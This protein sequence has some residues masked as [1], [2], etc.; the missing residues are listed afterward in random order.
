MSDRRAP[1]VSFYDKT[2][3]FALHLPHALSQPARSTAIILFLHAHDDGTS[4]YL[5][6]DTLMEMT[7][8]TRSAQFRALKELIKAGYLLDDGWQ[9]YANGAKTRRRRLDLGAM[10]TAR[11]AEKPENHSATDGTETSAHS[12]TGG[13]STVPPMEHKPSLEPSLKRPPIIPR[14]SQSLPGLEPPPNLLSKARP[15]PVET[16]TLVDAWNHICGAKGIPKVAAMT[17]ARKT[18]LLAR[19]AELGGTDP[20]WFKFCR[21]ISKSPLL[22][23][24]NDRE[25]RAGFDWCLKPANF[26]KII[27]GNYDPKGYQSGNREARFEAS[28]GTI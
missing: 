1:M 22:T 19:Y 11:A 10:A 4:I 27:E 13:I 24:D 5:S 12:P 7:A 6:V 9:A 8:L 23:G 17:D 3:Q 14:G 20:D 25:W 26:L 2:K 21:R 28:P 15:A 18:A 16:S